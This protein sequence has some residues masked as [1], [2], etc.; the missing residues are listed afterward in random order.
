MARALSAGGRGYFRKSAVGVRLRFPDGTAREVKSG[1]E[2]GSVT[3][4]GPATELTLYAS[5]R[6]GHARVDI[7]GSPDSVALF[8]E[9]LRGI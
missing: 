7:E 2:F 8:R 1:T 6:T 4:G 9:S 3:L 5:G